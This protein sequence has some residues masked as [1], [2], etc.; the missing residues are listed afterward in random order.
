MNPPLDTGMLPTCDPTYATKTS[1]KVGLDSGM[2]E[3]PKWKGSKLL[4][5]FP[6]DMGIDKTILFV[7]KF[8]ENPV[9][10]RGIPYENGFDALCICNGCWAIPPKGIEVEGPSCRA[11]EGT[12]YK[13]AAVVPSSVVNE[14]TIGETLSKA[15]T[16]AI[17]SKGNILKV[18]FSWS[19]SL[20]LAKSGFG[21]PTIGVFRVAWTGLGVSSISTE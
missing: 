17:W 13:A 9:V 6:K 21:S 14:V 4:E 12:G 11:A 10:T 15:F 5:V 1:P 20:K 16:V 7:N 2:W 8:P 3:F 18:L 19:K